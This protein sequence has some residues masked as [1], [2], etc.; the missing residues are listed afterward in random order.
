MLSKLFF[1]PFKLFFVYFTNIQ[2]SE[3]FFE[4]CSFLDHFLEENLSYLSNRAVYDEKDGLLCLL[5]YFP[6]YH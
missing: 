2:R 5:F 6:F 1:V 3:G 4:Q